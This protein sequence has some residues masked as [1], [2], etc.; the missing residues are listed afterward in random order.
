MRRR[1][2]M[3]KQKNK[4]KRKIT[5]IQK[6]KKFWG[7]RSPKNTFNDFGKKIFLITGCINFS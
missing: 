5:K 3:S 1:K 2:R 6:R 4:K 7:L